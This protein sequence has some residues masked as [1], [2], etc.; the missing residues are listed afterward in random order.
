M[1]LL[2]VMVSLACAATSPLDPPAARHL[3]YLHGRIIQDQQSARPQHPEYG[4]YE[5]AKIAD[6]FRQ[7][8]FIVRADIRPKAITVSEAADEVVEQVRSLLRAGVPPDHITVVGASMGAAIAL[9][10]SARLREPEVRFAFL[11]PCLSLNIPAVANEEGT[12]PSGYLLGI[13]EESDIPSSS[14]PRFGETELP[15]KARAREIVIH[16]GLDHGFLYRPLAEW[17]EPV[18]EWAGQGRPQ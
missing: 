11:G 17:L 10:A 12:S 6:A 16:T 8:G 3:I 14:C 1:A 13:R 4:H 5:L 18:V 2:A 9:R 15:A 7:R